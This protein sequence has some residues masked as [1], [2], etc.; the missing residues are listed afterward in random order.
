VY[1]KKKLK[2]LTECKGVVEKN[3]VQLRGWDYPHIPRKQ[4]DDI[5]MW[6]GENFYEGRENWFNHI[7]LWRMYQSGQFVHYVALRDDWAEHSGWGITENKNTKA[8]TTLNTIGEVIYEFTE[9]F[10]FLSRLAKSGLYDDGVKVSLT[11]Y[12]TKGRMLTTSPERFLFA[13]YVTDLDSISFER[14]CSKEEMVTG[15]KELALEAIVHLFERFNWQNIP[16]DA[17]KSDQERLLTRRV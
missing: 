11:L 5:G 13:E 15:S 6:A 16:V 1:D 7:E 8:G 4:E 14:E 9:I 10:E 3:S 12:K 2:T 17:I